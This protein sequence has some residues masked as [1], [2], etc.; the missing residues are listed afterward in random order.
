MDPDHEHNI[1]LI[2]QKY[3]IYITGILQEYDRNNDDLCPQLWM[4]SGEVNF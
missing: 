4:V 3:Y 2:L 1:T